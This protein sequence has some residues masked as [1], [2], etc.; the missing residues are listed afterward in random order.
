[1]R[2]WADL[3]AVTSTLKNAVGRYWRLRQADP[4]LL[5]LGSST[6]EKR[7]FSPKT[8]QKSFGSARIQ[9]TLG[10]VLWGTIF[11]LSTAASDYLNKGRLKSLSVRHQGCLIPGIVSSNH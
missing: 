6:D 11:T 1:V 7:I 8:M 4:A 10:R 3:P 9:D 5:D 2:Q